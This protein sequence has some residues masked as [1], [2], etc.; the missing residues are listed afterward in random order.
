[1]KHRGEC[2]GSI[3]SFVSRYENHFDTTNEDTSSTDFEITVNVFFLARCETVVNELIGL[4]DRFLLS[5]LD[6]TIYVR[7]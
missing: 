5:D 7:Q 4:L 6:F 2:S 3:E 1:M